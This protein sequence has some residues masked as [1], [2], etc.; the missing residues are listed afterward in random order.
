MNMEQVSRAGETTQDVREV[1]G[2]LNQLE[3]AIDVNINSFGILE[4]RLAPLIISC[5]EA[6]PE[7]EERKC[8]QM[9]EVGTRLTRFIESVDSLT[10]RIQKLERSLGI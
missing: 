1:T 9:C 8:G 4:K 6:H 10:V 2:L 3:K 5:L 7:E